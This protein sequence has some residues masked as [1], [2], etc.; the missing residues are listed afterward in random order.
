MRRFL[1]VCSLLAAAITAP[2]QLTFVFDYTYDTGSFFSGGNI[3]NRTYLEA[4]G[5]YLSN[6]ISGTTLNAITPGGGNSWNADTFH[7]GTGDNQVLGN[8]SI[9]ANTILV[10]AGGYD[11]GGST[12]GVGGGGGYGVTGTQPW[13]DA[14]SYRGNG[15]FSMPWG[16]SIA[17]DSSGTS[18]HF[19]SDTSTT[20]TFTGQSDFFSVAVH[21]LMHLVGVGTNATWDSLISGT[22]PTSTFTGAASVAENGGVILL[23]PGEGH[24]VNGT[25]STIAG[26]ATPQETLMDPSIVIGTRKYLTDLDL[27]ALQDLGYT[28]TA[29]P[30]PATIA[31]LFGLAAMLS[32]IRRRRTS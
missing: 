12:L 10:F 23:D 24:W 5:T 1:L 17:F 31:A 13:L 14:I 16:G 8:I 26:T 18:W 25:M 7:P 20:E 6:Y 3:G 28:V 27:A 15:S 9:A 19:D 11:L 30:E 22:S 4:A 32:V 21:E 2:A 29:V